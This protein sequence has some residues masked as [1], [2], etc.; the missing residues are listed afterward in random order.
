MEAT[1]IAGDVYCDQQNRIWT[2]QMIPA[3]YTAESILLL[4][5]DKTESGS[6]FLHGFLLYTKN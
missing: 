6:R 4:L 5:Q 3:Q 1:L 2:M